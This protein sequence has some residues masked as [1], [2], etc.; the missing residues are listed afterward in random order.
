VQ[1]GNEINTTE[2][3]KWLIR[4]QFD[5]NLVTLYDVQVIHYKT[6]YTKETKYSTRQT[7]TEFQSGIAIVLVC[8]MRTWE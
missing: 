3:A 1:V 8:L 5:R 2:V 4:S 6:T 7:G